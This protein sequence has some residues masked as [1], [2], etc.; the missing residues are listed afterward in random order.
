MTTTP[1]DAPVGPEQGPRPRADELRDLGRLRR[2]TT[3]RHVAGVA[4]GLGR[5]L[6]IDPVILRVAFVV[7]IFFGGA[8]LLLYGACWLLVPQDDGTEAP[9]RLDDRTR[10]IVL[11]VAAGLAGLALA[12]DSWGVIGFPWPLA[13]LG[14]IA[15]VLV[16]RSRRQGTPPPPRPYQHPYGP[17]PYAQYPYAQQYAAPAAP[18]AAPADSPDATVAP[19]PDAPADTPVDAPGA[20][21][22]TEPAGW[23][24]GPYAAPYAGPGTPYVW[25]HVAPPTPPN[26]A[27]RG[28]RLF[29][30][31]MAL[32][33]LGVGILGLIDAAG[34]P[35]P[36][37]AYAALVTATCGVM[38]LVG[39]FFGRTGGLIPVGLVAA[40][41]MGGTAVGENLTE[42][43]AQY[44]PLTSLE[45][46]SS[47]DM[48]AGDLVLDLTALEDPEALAGRS[49]EIDGGVGRVEV[50]VPDD[51]R[52][53][54]TA[55]VG[56]GSAEVFEHDDGG[57]G[58][59]S[60]GTTGPSGEALEITADLGIGRVRVHTESQEAGR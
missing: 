31:A 54:V 60:T 43:D 48:D 56:I 41:V 32:A 28:P 53:E 19:A 44:R 38:L 22:Q 30:P 12:G 13:I 59:T 23:S 16:T 58:I 1:P 5:H 47:Y 52:V 7:L 36:D 21:P 17:H 4:G 37:S 45:V 3:D 24:T 50:I 9:V 10:S 8:G 27:R 39:A 11:L 29:W 51:L 33:A 14:A 25:Q 55:D 18:G 26:P 40:L 35:V 6:D 57:L 2:S 49:I 42:T 46:E 34:A 15:L 20:A